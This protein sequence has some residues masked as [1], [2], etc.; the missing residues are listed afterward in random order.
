MTFPE[1]DATL[2]TD[3]SF[4]LQSQPEHHKGSF[5]SFRKDRYRFSQ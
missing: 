3:E 1:L 4:A 2:R 5:Y